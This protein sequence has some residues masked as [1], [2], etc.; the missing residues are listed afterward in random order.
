MFLRN[1][2]QNSNK[3][4]ERKRESRETWRARSCGLSRVE[5][6][7]LI[8]MDSMLHVGKDYNFSL[9]LVL[10][11][12]YSWQVPDNEVFFELVSLICHSFV[13]YHVLARV[14]RRLNSI[15]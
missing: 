10:R 4:Q 5:R 6:K 13:K 11:S 7:T 8:I 15:L 12:Q 9:I 2:A 3:P 14:L 1:L